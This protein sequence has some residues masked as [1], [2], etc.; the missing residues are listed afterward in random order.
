MKIFINFKSYAISPE[1]E[2][3]MPLHVNISPSD[4]WQGHSSNSKLLNSNHLGAKMQ[5]G[6]T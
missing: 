1:L 3:D 6:K 2:Y 4:Q 5:D